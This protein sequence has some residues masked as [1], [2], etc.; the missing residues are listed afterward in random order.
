[1]Y[2]GGCWCCGEEDKRGEVS[3]KATVQTNKSVMIS[4]VALPSLHCTLNVRVLPL[5]CSGYQTSLTA[6]S[7]PCARGLCMAATALNTL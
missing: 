5:L 1:M 2:W 4:S 3:F 7:V 6:G